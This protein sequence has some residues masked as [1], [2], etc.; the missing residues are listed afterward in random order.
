[1]DRRCHAHAWTLYFAVPPRRS[2]PNASQGRWT[3]K[4]GAPAPAVHKPTAI[5]MGGLLGPWPPAPPGPH[6]AGQYMASCSCRGNTA[7]QRLWGCV[8]GRA[9]K[10]AVD[11]Y[12]RS[13]HRHRY[14]Q[15]WRGYIAFQAASTRAY[16]YIRARAYAQCQ[17][18]CTCTPWY[19]FDVCAWPPAYI[20][21]FC[22]CIYWPRRG[23][24]HFRDRAREF[25]CV[26]GCGRGP[27]LGATCTRGVMHLNALFCPADCAGT[28]SKP[29]SCTPRAMAMAP[30]KDFPSASRHGKLRGA[31]TFDF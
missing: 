31:R 22:L 20:T 11:A 25:P 9:P 2:I 30:R 6:M 27:G 18:A 3:W 16:I 24:A 19:A 7:A 1:M 8:H 14:R 21:K 15:A 26:W 13:G 28:A 23:G 12:A 29:V 4:G 5:P 10:A 17:C